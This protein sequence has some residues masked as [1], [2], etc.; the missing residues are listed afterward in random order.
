MTPPPLP[1]LDER[2]TWSSFVSGP[3]A[4]ANR[5]RDESIAM[6]QAMVADGRVFA[7]MPTEART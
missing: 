4:E 5:R 1:L 3:L 7:A 2:P 6:L